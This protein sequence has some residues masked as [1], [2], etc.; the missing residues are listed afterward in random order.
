MRSLTEWRQGISPNENADVLL[1]RLGEIAQS[2]QVE[3]EAFTGDRPEGFLDLCGA[4]KELKRRVTELQMGIT[5]DVPKRLTGSLAE[6]AT[7]KEQ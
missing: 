6:Y 7:R 5:D 3:L 4:V 2:A 1:D